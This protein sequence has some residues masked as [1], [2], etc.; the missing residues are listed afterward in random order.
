MPRLLDR[1]FVFALG[2]SVLALGITAGVMWWGRE[3]P[4]R[5]LIGLEGRHDGPAGGERLAACLDCHVPFVGTPGS[6]CLGPGCHG[7]LATG[8]PP[9]DGPA[10]PIRFHAVLRDQPC[11]LCHEEHV[12]LGARTSTRTFGHALIPEAPRALCARCHSGAALPSHAATDAVACSLCHGTERWSDV[13][14]DHAKVATQACDLCHHAPE[15]TAHASI[16]GNCQECHTSDRWQ[17][18]RTE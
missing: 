2:T 11:A 10:M 12:E 9:R 17:A 7:E 3:S 6:R 4:E 5:V 16:A 18:K 8:T 15:D 14:I 13:T 1:P